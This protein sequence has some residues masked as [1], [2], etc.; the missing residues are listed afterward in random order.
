MEGEG[1][2]APAP[3]ALR[4]GDSAGGAARLAWL[5]T[6]ARVAGSGGAGARRRAHSD[7]LGEAGAEGSSLR[8]GNAPP[9]A[10][11]RVA[12]SLP[13]AA[14]REA[15]WM[16]EMWRS[17]CRCPRAWREKDGCGERVGLVAAAAAAEVAA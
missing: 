8:P 7:A 9:A 17:R 5:A 13:P 2:S 15:S 12:S 10:A 1:S 4:C 3:P 16:R 6:C 14:P 11:V